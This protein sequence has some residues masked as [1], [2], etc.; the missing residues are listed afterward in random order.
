MQIVAVD[1]GDRVIKG[2][3]ARVELVRLEWHSVLRQHQDGDAPLCVG[4]RE[5]L[6]ADRTG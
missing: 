1:A 6:R 5:H 3:P 4:E 2:F